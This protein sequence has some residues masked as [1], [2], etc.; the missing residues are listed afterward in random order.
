MPA[1]VGRDF[2]KRSRMTQRPSVRIISLLLLVG[3]LAAANGLMA[4]AQ[5]AQPGS[6]S[7]GPSPDN[8]VNNPKNPARER[9][10]ISK[11][12]FSFQAGPGD[13]ITDSLRVVNVGRVPVSVLVYPVDATTGKSTGLVLMDRSSPKAGVSTWVELEA[14]TLDL[15]GGETRDVRFTVNVPPSAP[16]GEHWGGLIVEDTNV[17]GDPTQFG[18]R[19]VV[20]AGVSL[21][22]T[23]PGP[24]SERLAIRGVSQR[25]ANTL[26]QVFTI[27]IA[28]EGNVMLKPE[29]ALE[30]TDGSGKTVAR[31]DLKLNNVLARTSVPYEL[32]WPD[33][34]VPSGRYTATVTLRPS[35][36]ASPV[37]YTVPDLEVQA[38]TNELVA[39]T[40]PGGGQVF[41]VQPIQS[42]L[43]ST[44]RTLLPAAGGGAIVGLLFLANRLIRR[45][46]AKGAAE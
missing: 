4:H 3:G 45:L 37:V 44:L 35:P 24:R 1:R 39:Q 8:D 19:Q 17:R 15:V 33:A 21:G 34:T 31:L 36:G 43:E 23:L 10:E 40:S 9:S 28:N 6:F 5:Q 30:L 11:S 29:G 38:P 26:D 7:V 14:Q 13:Q 32:V 2:I 27:D 25:V 46:R 22:V 42:P 16:S 41:T 20:R 18:V 12:W